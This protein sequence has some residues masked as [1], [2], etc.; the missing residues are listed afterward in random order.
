MI[1]VVEADPH[2]HLGSFSFP[3]DRF[4][5]SRAPGAWLF[6]KDMFATPSG[7]FRNWGKLIVCSCDN[8]DFNFWVLRCNSPIGQSLCS[9]KALS[10]I[11]RTVGLGVAAE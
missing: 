7:N 10:Q 8:Y 9:R 11:L 1:A 4:Q 3:E 2:L 6:D 5:F